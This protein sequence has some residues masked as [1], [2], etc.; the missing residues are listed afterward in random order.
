MHIFP[1]DCPFS[2]ALAALARMDKRDVSFQ[3]IVTSPWQF[4]L[5][6]LQE[7]GQAETTITTGSCVDTS[8]D[9]TDDSSNNCQAFCDLGLDRCQEF[10]NEYYGGERAN[11]VCCCCGGGNQE[12]QGGITMNSFKSVPWVFQQPEADHTKQ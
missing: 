5:Q 10:G 3:E 11:D 6:N 8:S 4:S 7:Q 9:W 2:G 1:R 12:D